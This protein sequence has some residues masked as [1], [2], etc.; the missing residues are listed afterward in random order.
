MTNQHDVVLPDLDGGTGPALP[1]ADAKMQAMIG[2][3][4]T[5]GMGPGGDGGPTGTDGGSGVAGSGASTAG[6]VAAKVGL[7]G[8][9]AA[10]AVVAVVVFSG[11][12]ERSPMNTQAVPVVLSPQPSTTPAVVSTPEAKPTTPATDVRAASPPRRPSSKPTVR[13]RRP[14]AAPAPVAAKTPDDLL[15]LA[16]RARKRRDWTAANGFYTR[17][18]TLH[19]GTR[20]AYVASVASAQLN[21]GKLGRAGVAL[22]LFTRALR[23][24]PRGFLREE[25]QY[26]VAQANA[27]LGNRAAETTALRRF[28]RDHPRSALAPRARAR[29][30]ELSGAA[31]DK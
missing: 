31:S 22:K 3:A 6:A 16:N 2:A 30:V 4:I 29:L 21:L 24:E 20:A 19:P 1:I 17:V 13:T 23:Q 27:K 18:R 11:A 5:G 12:H 9:G 28:V 15:R 25:A 26:G 10:A 7:V 8:L 14:S